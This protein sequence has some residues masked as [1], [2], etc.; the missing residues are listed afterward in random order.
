M[1]NPKFRIDITATREKEKIS[2]GSHLDNVV[3]RWDGGMLKIAATD[4]DHA[5]RLMAELD[6]A[7]YVEVT[8]WEKSSTAS[9]RK[10][11]R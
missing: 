10:E 5:K 8:T 4:E 7:A 9:R 11:R 2:D 1:S 6:E 3:M